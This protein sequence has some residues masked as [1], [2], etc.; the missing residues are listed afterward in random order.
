MT[1]TPIQKPDVTRVEVIDDRG[2]V[3]VAY[4]RTVGV[5]V[6]TQDDGRTIKVFAGEPQ[7]EGWTPPWP[8]FPE[9]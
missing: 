4:Y 7:P 6:H 8:L 9:R 3:F 1:D 2:R 5:E